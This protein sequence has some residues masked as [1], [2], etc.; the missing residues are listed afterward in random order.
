MLILM[1]FLHITY[2]IA[3]T[4]N[5]YEKDFIVKVENEILHLIFVGFFLK[6][7]KNHLLIYMNTAKRW[8]ILK[9][10]KANLK[11]IE[12]KLIHAMYL[13]KLMTRYY[14]FNTYLKQ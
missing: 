2:H 5:L 4:T 10:D 6:Y 14:K 11:S 12:P 1:H 13:F 7:M 3:K 9:L 8:A